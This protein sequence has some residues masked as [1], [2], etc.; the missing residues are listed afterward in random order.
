MNVY[1]CTVS[2]QQIHTANYCSTGAPRL[3]SPHTEVSH[4]QHRGIFYKAFHHLIICTNIL[5]SAYCRTQETEVSVPRNIAPCE[6][7]YSSAV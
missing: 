4:Q 5:G 2:G 7:F 6:H 1:E 3:N